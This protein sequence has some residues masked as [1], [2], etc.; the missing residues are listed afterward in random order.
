MGLAILGIIC[1][2][3][4]FIILYKAQNISFEKQEEQE[5]Y[6][7]ALQIKINEIKRQINQQKEKLDKIEVLD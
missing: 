7:E 6:K 3:I 4:A 1:I 2:I 5:R